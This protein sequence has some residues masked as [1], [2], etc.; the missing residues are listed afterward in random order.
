MMKN[1]Q[2]KI[3][4][5]YWRLQKKNGKGDGEGRPDFFILKPNNGKIII[6]EC[7]GDYKKHKSKHFPDPLQGNIDV[8]FGSHS[9]EIRNYAS[10]GVLWY[11][12][13]LKEYYD[14]IGIAISGQKN[15]Y[16]ID[17][18]YWKKKNK[19]Y[20]NLNIYNEIRSFDDYLKHI[21]NIENVNQETSDFRKISTELN[22]ELREYITLREEEKPLFVAS[23]LLALKANR[24]VKQSY[25]KTDESGNYELLDDNLNSDGTKNP[26]LK[27]S[28]LCYLINKDAISF[29][30][31]SGIKDNKIEA[32]KSQFG[33]I[34]GREEFRRIN[35]TLNKNPLRYFLQKVDEKIM[36]YFKNHTFDALG[37]FYNEFLHYGGGDGSGLGIA[38]TPSH[39]TNLFSE[40]ANLT[41]KSVVLDPCTGTGG[42]LVSAMDNMISKA[43][44]DTEKIKQIKLSNLIGIEQQPY[45]FALASSNMI[46][47]GDGKSNLYYS[48]CFND[49]L[50][51][52]IKIKKRPNVGMINPPYGQGKGLEEWVF[53]KHM[54]SMLNEGGTG[55]AIIP[56]SCLAKDK[57]SAIR[58]EILRNNTLEAVMSMPENLFT[59]HGKNSVHTC[60]CVFTSGKPHPLNYKTWFGY[61]RNDGFEVSG[62][63]RVDKFNKWENIKKAWLDMYNEKKTIASIS[64][65]GIVSPDGDWT[66]ECFL[67]IDYS[68]L[69]L[70]DFKK[71][72]RE[73][74]SDIMKFFTLKDIHNISREKIKKEDI[75]NTDINIQNW[76][77]FKINEL[78]YD[79]VTGVKTIES[80]IAKLYLEKY[81]RE[82]YLN[83]TEICNF[84]TAKNNSNGIGGKYIGKAEFDGNVLSVVKQGDGGIGMTFYQNE[85]FCSANT[86]FVLKPRYEKF[87]EYIGIFITTILQKHRFRYSF[88][89]ALK[90]CILNETVVY[91]PAK[92]INS[93]K[94][95]NTHVPDY[96]YM[97]K[98]MKSLIA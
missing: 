73:Y 25:N 95:I 63:R 41:T 13:F 86:V 58:I 65:L 83:D 3:L 80:K 48:S 35:P 62:G 16:L 72:Y 56:I 69:S 6:V 14:V 9:N 89:R 12:S 15:Y 39:I 70:V 23:L 40:L 32:L 64:T 20:T 54:L 97:E 11:M 38:L 91:L 18:Y 34:E 43:N 66:P 71:K 47:R 50:V 75:I 29:L 37:S 74:I 22:K 96:E 44:S 10:D 79:A 33:F 42:F 61:W 68:E 94:Q 76:K 87:N 93:D 53:V 52:E 46:L 5:D 78:F 57:D 1:H 24:T 19:T 82:E 49:D 8:F 7:K 88:G 45:M 31:K 85:P 2:L 4:M 60:I 17:N 77:P 28:T 55:I 90:E 59:V 98:Y 26:E 36:K 27:D 21:K 67:D 51:N 81:M 30:S 92:K 84:I